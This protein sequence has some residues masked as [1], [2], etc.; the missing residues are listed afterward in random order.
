MRFE[1]NK[2]SGVIWRWQDVAVDQECGKRPSCRRHAFIQFLIML[3]VAA[4]L[5]FLFGLERLATV[6]FCAG[7]ILVIVG[8]CAPGLFMKITGLMKKIGRVAGL[9]ITWV[10]LAPFF[11]L[12]FVPGRLMMLLKGVDPMSRRCPSK[13]PT[14]WV[15]R[16]SVLRGPENYRKQY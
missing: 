14:Y 2:V 16:K 6:L 8:F 11:Y 4:V 1:Q 12:V 5:R 10:V 9:V 3:M 15:D 13:E 7:V